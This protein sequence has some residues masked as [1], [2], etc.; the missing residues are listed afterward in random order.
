MTT[1]LFE[2]YEIRRKKYKPGSIWVEKGKFHT[3]RKLIIL[4]DEEVKTRRIFRI[5][6]DP[7]PENNV[8]FKVLETSIRCNDLDVNKIVSWSKDYMENNYEPL[9]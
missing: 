3:V 2:K 9:S 7:M 1:S 6:I 8:T 5:Y 4:S